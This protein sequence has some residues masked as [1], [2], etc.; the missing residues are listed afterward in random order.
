MSLG[1]LWINNL[2]GLG[3]SE[4]KQAS[5]HKYRFYSQFACEDRDQIWCRA[6]GKL[7]SA[8]VLAGSDGR[9]NRG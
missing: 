8:R 2:A 9:M 3:E 7:S 4:V 6:G 1:P 5:Q